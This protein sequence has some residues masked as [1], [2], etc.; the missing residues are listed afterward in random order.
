MRNATVLTVEDEREA[1]ATRRKRGMEA[2]DRALV[3][4]VTLTQRATDIRMKMLMTE[5]SASVD[6]Y[7]RLA[8]D[9]AAR[10]EELAS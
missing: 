8:R 7:A 2:V 9:L 1:L 6:Y 4:L 10:L 3:T 5:S